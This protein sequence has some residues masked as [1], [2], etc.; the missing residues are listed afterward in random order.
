MV[1][2]GSHGVIS[3]AGRAGNFRL[4]QHRP[5]EDG[6]YPRGWSEIDPDG[7]V[8]STGEEAG[9]NSGIGRSGYTSGKGSAQTIC[10]SH[11]AMLN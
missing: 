6:P 5:A 4:Y 9:K 10:L 7:H 1:I 3:S 11:R 8:V 2:Y